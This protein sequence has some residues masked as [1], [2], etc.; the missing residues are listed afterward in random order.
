MTAK[1]PRSG[2]SASLVSRIGSSAAIQVF[3]GR[4]LSA[5]LYL[6]KYTNRFEFNPPDMFERLAAERPVIFALWH[7]QHFM[8]PLIKR[9]EDPETV[10]ISRHGDG[11]IMAIA[12]ASFGIRPIRASGSKPEKMHERGGITGL[13][14]MLRALAQGESVVLTADRPKQPRVAGRGIVTLARL[15]RRPIYPLAVVTSRRITLG[16][17]DRTSIGLPFGRGIGAIGS[18]VWV[19]CDA[20]ANAAETARR[21]VEAGLDEVHQ[22]AYAL[23]SSRDPGAELRADR[24][25]LTDNR[26]P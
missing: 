5:Y 14:E 4:V 22:R 1:A 18:P 9:I 13:R 11:T 23:V 3:L 7:G 25:T 10:L 15:S 17:W 26:I 21:A 6:G 19:A 24:R 20:D 16:N 8:I 2:N 12:C